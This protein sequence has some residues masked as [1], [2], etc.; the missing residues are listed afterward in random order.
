MLCSK[1]GLGFL[2]ANVVR[3]KASSI[4][5]YTYYLHGSSYGL[6]SWPGSI[7]RAYEF[8]VKSMLAIA[9]GRKLLKF[10]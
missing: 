1:L 4:A 5:R 2:M 9:R 7:K 6:S 8:T 10:F 3:A